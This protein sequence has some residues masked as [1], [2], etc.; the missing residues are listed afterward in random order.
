MVPFEQRPW[1]KCA[2]ITDKLI[3]ALKSGKY[4]YVAQVDASKN[5]YLASGIKAGEIVKFRVAAVKGNVIGE[6]SNYLKTSTTPKQGNIKSVKS[7]SKKK[8]T[9]SYSSR[10]CTGYEIQWSTT[11]DFSSNYKSVRVGSSTTTK[12]ITTAQSRKAYFVRVRSYVKAGGVTSYGKWSPA[13]LVTT[14]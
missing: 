13:R 6:K 5:N 14:K 1:M 7:K 2:E 9:V 8:I 10:A 4:D 11:K 3:E 12:T